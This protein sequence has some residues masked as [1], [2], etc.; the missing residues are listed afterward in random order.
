MTSRMLSPLALALAAGLI[1]V[2]WGQT[3]PPQPQT[4]PQTQPT[5]P[6]TGSQPGH[7]GDHRFKGAGVGVSLSLGGGERRVSHL[8]FFRT[9]GPIDEEATTFQATDWMAARLSFPASRTPLYL[10]A[11]VDGVWVI[12]NAPVASSRRGDQESRWYAFGLGAPGKVPSDAFDYAFA[13]PP[14]PLEAPPPVQ[15][16]TSAKRQ[17]VVLCGGPGGNSGKTQAAPLDG[18]ELAKGEHPHTQANFPNQEAELN[19]CV[20]VGISNSLQWLN[21]TQKLGLD[22]KDISPEGLDKLFGRAK[23]KGT[24]DSWVKKKVDKFGKKIDTSE[25][26]IADVAAAI[27]KGC[28]VELVAETHLAA[29]VGISKLANGKYSVDVAH[30]TLQGQAGGTKVETLIIPGTDQTIKG[31]TFLD[32]TKVR[33]FVC[34]CKK[35]DKPKKK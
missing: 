25:I 30:D 33:T 2:A 8:E 19:A 9:Y 23:G 12:R 14:K 6:P 22:K 15:A 4:Q 21:D 13:L 32:G 3:T 5:Q 17:E 16:K 31:G 35:P 29:V 28:D 26:G 34:E 24:G 20:P 27:D 7:G 18:G 10:N 11:Q 1:G